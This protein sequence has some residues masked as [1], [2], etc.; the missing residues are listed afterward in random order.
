MIKQISS[1]ELAK[2]C[3]N[4]LEIKVDNVEK[5]T[6]ILESKLGATSYKVTPDYVIQVY[7]YLDQPGVISKL[8]I[9]NG[10]GLTSISVKE[11]NLEYY[12]MDLVGGDHHE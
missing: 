12:F 11:I 5:M 8:A 2:E 3:K 7:E 1:E 6:A 10:I 4:Y 9:D